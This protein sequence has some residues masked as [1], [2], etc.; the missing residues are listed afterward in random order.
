MISSPCYYVTLA[1]AK[2]WHWELLFS[3]VHYY[4]ANKFE[5]PIPAVGV[6]ALQNARCVCAR[7][8]CMDWS[9]ILVVFQ[10]QDRLRI[11]HR[12]DKAVTEDELNEYYL[13]VKTDF[14]PASIFLLCGMLYMSC[15]QNIVK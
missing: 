14:C 10:S 2:A 13:L 9:L 8:C 3:L 15:I 11:H 1:R 6:L 5:L 7:A 4:Y 12:Q